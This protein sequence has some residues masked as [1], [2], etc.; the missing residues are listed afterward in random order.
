MYKY[1]SFLYMY[2]VFPCVCIF[3]IS[4][5][6]FASCFVCIHSIYIKMDLYL[7][8]NFMHSTIALLPYNCL[9]FIYSYSYILFANPYI[10]NLF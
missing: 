2:N 7:L 10:F 8:Y 9:T 5:I 3:P 4:Y 1:P 6:P